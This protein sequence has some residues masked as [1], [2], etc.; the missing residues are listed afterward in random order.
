M[1]APNVTFTINKNKI[2][3]VSGFDFMQV[4]FYA[5]SSYKQF[6]C[7][8]TKAGSDW[9]LG[10]GSL[11]ATFSQTPANTSR[12]FEVYDDFLTN[13]DGEYRISL[14]VQGEDGAWNDTY[15]FVTSGTTKTMLTSDGKEFLCRKE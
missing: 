2:S 8:A 7:R 14:Y 6:E 9:G 13:G 3:A 12:T 1:G 15:G 4:T 5:D 10:I 11:I